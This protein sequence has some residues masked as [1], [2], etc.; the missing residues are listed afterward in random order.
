MSEYWDAL[1]SESKRPSPWTPT[2]KVRI[3]RGGVQVPLPRITTTPLGKQERFTLG[4]ELIRRI[5]L[6][7]D[8]EEVYK[9]L[10]NRGARQVGATKKGVDRYLRKAL[11]DAIEEGRL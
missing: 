11:L 6:G 8:P 10:L 4:E 5:Q 3:T 2:G 7:E 1:I 9:I